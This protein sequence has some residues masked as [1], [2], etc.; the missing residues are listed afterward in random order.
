M[1]FD[2]GLICRVLE[3]SSDGD[4]SWHVLD[5]QTLQTFDKRF[6][7]KTFKVVSPDLLSNVFR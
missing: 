6:Q 5:E 7:R 4:L 2:V 1:Y 3:G